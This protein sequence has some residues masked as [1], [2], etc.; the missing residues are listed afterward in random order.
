MAC[1][2]IDLPAAVP[3]ML[4]E[5]HLAPKLRNLIYDIAREKKFCGEDA[6]LQGAGHVLLKAGSLNHVLLRAWLRMHGL[7]SVLQK[8]ECR[9]DDVVRAPAFGAF[10]HRCMWA[11][12]AHDSTIPVRHHFNV[13][14]R[15]LVH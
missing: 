14:S 2:Q 10:G 9:F 15:G 5:L 12:S 6:A 4:N 1:I 3:K 8:R 11:E 13:R 7:S